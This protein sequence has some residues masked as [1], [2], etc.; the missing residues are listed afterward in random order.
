MF[1]LNII[2]TSIRNITNSCKNNFNNIAIDDID[3]CII[4]IEI[5]INDINI[6]YIKDK[7]YAINKINIINN[8]YRYIDNYLDSITD[9]KIYEQALRLVDNMKKEV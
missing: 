2:K 1:D 6:T 9:S 4:T 8:N 5:A 7:D 3:N